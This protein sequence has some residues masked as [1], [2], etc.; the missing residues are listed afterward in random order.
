MDK[1]FNE[2]LL[3]ELNNCRIHELRD[4]A[5]NYGVKSPTSLTKSQI[6]AELT[7]I[8]Q[9]KKEPYVNGS[10]VGR[11][12]LRLEDRSMQYKIDPNAYDD[13]IVIK[14]LLVDKNQNSSLY[15]FSSP[16]AYE[17]ANAQKEI[18]EGYFSLDFEAYGVVYRNVLSTN[19]DIKIPLY[20]VHTY[21]LRSGDY[22]KC[23]GKAF[24]DRGIFISEVLEVNGAKPP[25]PDRPRFE[26]MEHNKLSETL[27]CAPIFDL[28]FEI[29]EGG[30]YFVQYDNRKFLPE[31]SYEFAKSIAKTKKVVFININS[32]KN[33]EFLSDDNLIV[34]NLPIDI[35]Q[36]YIAH[37]TNTILVNCKRRVELGENLVVVMA[38]VGELIKIIDMAKKEFIDDKIGVQT[39]LWFNKVINS[40]KNSINGKLTLIAVESLFLPQYI[41]D[42]VVFDVVPKFTDYILK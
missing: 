30:S 24:G 10:K 42:I 26:E 41:K 11:P 40:A 39:V 3:N 22:V 25:I 7:E 27:M 2:D 18:L 38:N 4:I 21:G 1:Y 23:V 12:P 33:N 15:I 31:K 13:P 28:P 14:D 16:N 20:L 34:Y 29:K 35:E 37:A 19:C 9:G 32:D 5:R 17:N 36:K 8:S 6:I